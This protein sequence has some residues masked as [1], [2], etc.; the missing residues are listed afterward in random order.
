MA[1]TFEI[2]KDPS[3]IVNAD[4]LLTASSA[5]LSD[6]KTAILS[7]LMSEAYIQLPRHHHYANHDSLQGIPCWIIE[8]A[9]PSSP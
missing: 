2:S 8:N 7:S 5:S 1:Q 3:Q 4:E 6:H 9:R